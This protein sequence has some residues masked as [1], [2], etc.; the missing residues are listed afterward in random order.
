[1]LLIWRNVPSLRGVKPALTEAQELYP[2]ACQTGLAPSAQDASATA[3]PFM[4]KVCHLRV[5]KQ[6]KPAQWRVTP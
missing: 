4:A 1:M 2:T 6:R 3:L 5:T